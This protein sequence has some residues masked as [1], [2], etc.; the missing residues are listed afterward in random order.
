MEL[1]ERFKNNEYW[2]TLDLVVENE[3]GI[4]ARPS[5]QI[6]QR[7]QKYARQAYIVLLE[8][9]AEEILEKKNERYDCKQVI[10]LMAMGALKGTLLRLYVQGNDDY[11]KNNCKELG[12]LLSSRFDYH[13]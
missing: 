5:A 1:Q 12:E 2:T 11:A 13:L 8:S 10:S 7:A 6:T 4:H 9:L 3:A